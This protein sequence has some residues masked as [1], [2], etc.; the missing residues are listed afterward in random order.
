VTSTMPTS[1]Q[2]G[3]RPP[4]PA[5][6]RVALL[7][8]AAARPAAERAAAALRADGHELVVVDRD[9]PA[10]LAAAA[11]VLVLGGAGP[12]ARARALAPAGAYIR[13]LDL[14]GDPAGWD[15]AVL[16]AA[17]ATAIAVA[18]ARVGMCA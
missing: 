18:P 4:T 5:P 16:A 3:C 10:G 2:P 13:A 11:A 6:A 17:R 8:A 14:G 7:A 9:R 1:W 15:G 12:A